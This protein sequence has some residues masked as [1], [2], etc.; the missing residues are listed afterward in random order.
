MKHVMWQFHTKNF[1]VCATIDHDEDL[2]LSWDD[3]G[4]VR[5]KLETGEYEAFQTKVAV[6]YRGCE[7]SAEYLGGSIYA[8]P[9]DFFTEHYGLTA[10]SRADNCN[11]GSYFPGMVREAIAEAR[12]N[13]RNV[14]Y[15]RAT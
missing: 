7:V 9:H 10:K 13:L 1:S 14:P 4:E 12:K 15:I 2:D 6:Y 5:E 8:N 3:T 11:Y